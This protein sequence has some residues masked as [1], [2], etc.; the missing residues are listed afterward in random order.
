M[1]NSQ[2]QFVV[3]ADLLK[4]NLA[5]NDGEEYKG[6]YFNGGDK[7]EKYFDN[8]TGAHFKFQDICDKLSKVAYQREQVN[9]TPSI[10]KIRK[11]KVR[12]DATREFGFEQL[13]GYHLKSDIGCF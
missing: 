7:E 4:T 1:S 13:R 10:I 6:I 3:N 12:V 11:H 5:L 8:L 9:S 2:N